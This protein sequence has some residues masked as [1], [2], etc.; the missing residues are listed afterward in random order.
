MEFS[1]VPSPRKINDAYF[2][3]STLHLEIVIYVIK[4]KLIYALEHYQQKGSLEEILSVQ[5]LFIYELEGQKIDIQTIR[6]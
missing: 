6:K 5:N 3:T 2:F 4:V 1:I